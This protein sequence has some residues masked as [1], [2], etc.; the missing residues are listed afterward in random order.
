[1]LRKRRK[2]KNNKT[3]L[4]IIKKQIFQILNNLLENIKLLNKKTQIIKNRKLQSL[5]ASQKKISL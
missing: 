3:K 1:M 2:I 5:Q 4:I